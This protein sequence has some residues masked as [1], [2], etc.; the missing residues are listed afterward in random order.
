[1]NRDQRDE[2]GGK[3]SGNSVSS[4]QAGLPGQSGPA[5]A[6][7]PGGRNGVGPVPPPDQVLGPILKE[8]VEPVR[9]FAGPWLL[10]SLVV[11]LG[12]AGPIV[13]LLVT[14]LT[15]PRAPAVTLAVVVEF[16]AGAGVVAAAF[17]W[18]FPTRAPSGILAVLVIGA[19]L[20]SAA[21]AF[22]LPHVISGFPVAG[23]SAAKGLACVGW[24]F[25]AALP[26]VLLILW[27]LVQMPPFHAWLTGFLGGLGAGL[28]ADAANHL[29]CPA[30]DPAHTVTWHLGGVLLLGFVTAL[31]RG[32][33]TGR[34]S[35]RS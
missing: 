24:E 9:P 28:V 10:A 16:F 19:L 35:R 11:A 7:G 22:L 23:L 34:R 26:L 17:L 25:G 15:A 12:L 20:L 27:F 30:L 31:L 1:M 18:S 5:R 13:V 8:G 4:A 14:G 33:L 3:G 6:E 29:H 2:P 21:I 32:L